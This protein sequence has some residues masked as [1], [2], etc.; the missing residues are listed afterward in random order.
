ML[1]LFT[2]VYGEK[3][4]N[5]FEK[6]SPSIGTQKAIWDIYTDPQS[7]KRAVEIASRLGMKIEV[8]SQVRTGN[9]GEELQKFLISHLDLCLKTNSDLLICPPDSIF[10]EESIQNMISIAS[11]EPGICVSVPHVRANSDFLDTY[12]NILSNRELVKKAFEHLH[13]SWK[14]SEMTLKEN[15]I[16]WSGTAWRRLDKGLYAVIHRLPTPYLVRPLPKDLEY[17]H[18]DERLGLWD[19]RWPEMLVKDQRQRVI[20]SSDGAFIVELTD[21]NVNHPPLKSLDFSPDRYRGNMLHHQVNR[22]MV[23]IWRE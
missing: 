2:L 7:E 22:N 8:H 5:W 14:D 23:S 16:W 4:L 21:P 1:R 11:A 12:S 13:K 10:G 6:T 15:N 3:Y 19:H 17:F 9:A 18:G 20:G